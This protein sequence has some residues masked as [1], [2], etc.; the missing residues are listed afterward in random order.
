M[1]GWLKKRQLNEQKKLLFQNGM[2]SS[3]SLRSY[4]EAKGDQE[5]VARLKEFEN[6]NRRIARAVSDDEVASPEDTRKL[7]DMNRE[8][9]R[10]FDQTA[11]RH[12]GSF[13]DSYKPIL[14]WNE[15]Y[16]G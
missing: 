9:R 3:S 2:A 10:L 16:K 7:L 13:D 8:L 11:M 4:F 6:E 5:R 15:Y 1:F 12:V 14:G